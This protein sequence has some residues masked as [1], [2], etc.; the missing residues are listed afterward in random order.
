[1]K[2]YRSRFW[3]INRKH[4]EVEE[5]I[6]KD[7]KSM[8]GRNMHK[9]LYNEVKKKKRFVL[10]SVKRSVL[11][12]DMKDRVWKYS[13]LSCLNCG[14]TRTFAVSCIRLLSN[15][16][17]SGGA[18][19]EREEAGGNVRNWERKRGM[20]E[21][22]KRVRKGR[23]TEKKPNKRRKT[24]AICYMRYIARIKLYDIFV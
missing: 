4:T 5:H 2:E 23:I 21:D 16:D 22:S 17:V 8:C 20:Q 6:G 1:M 10:Q 15:S 14:F 11:L 7:W 9:C 18:E 3:S 12:H 19:N 24:I 13:D